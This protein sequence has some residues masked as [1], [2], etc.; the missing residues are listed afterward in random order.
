MDYF[1]TVP[2]YLFP[3]PSVTMMLVTFRGFLLWAVNISCL[4]YVIR[5][6]RKILRNE[7]MKKNQ[8][9]RPDFGYEREFNRPEV[10][11]PNSIE[12]T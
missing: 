7:L 10:N 1:A 6:V 5:G 8:P 2:A 12:V 3:M 4:I 11:S 9:I